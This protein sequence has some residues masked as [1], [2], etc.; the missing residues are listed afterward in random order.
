MIL[1]R[2]PGGDL[3][4]VAPGE[5]LWM[6]QAF[7]HE[8]SGTVMLRLSGHRIYSAEDLT[9]LRQTF[10]DAAVGLA[11]FTPPEGELVMVVNAK[12]VRE[13]E[14]GNPIIHHELARAVLKF[15]PKLS[16]AVRETVEEARSKLTA[17]GGSESVDL[18]RARRR[19]THA[20]S[21]KAVAKGRRT[22]K[23]KRDR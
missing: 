4:Y 19:K 5:F 8:W 22:A 18:S 11:E 13:V 12:N 15:G 2:M 7:D 17:A 20:R 3:E 21:H 1:I 14:P 6:R 9:D 10:S 16:L 23:R